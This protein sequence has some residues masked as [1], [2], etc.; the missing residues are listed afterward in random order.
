MV[1]KSQLGVYFFAGCHLFALSFMTLIVLA[2]QSAG[3]MKSVTGEHFHDLV[4]QGL[5]RLRKE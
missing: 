2:L 5:E 3:L 1:E 4:A